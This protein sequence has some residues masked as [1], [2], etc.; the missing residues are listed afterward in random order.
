MV[1]GT[2]IGQCVNLD[3]SPKTLNKTVSRTPWERSRDSNLDLHV[4]LL[5][6]FHYSNNCVFKRESK[7]IVH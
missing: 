5:R 6:M 7:I 4:S 3:I 1:Y 2:T